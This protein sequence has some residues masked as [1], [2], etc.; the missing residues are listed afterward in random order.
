MIK[1]DAY[2][3]ELSSTFELRD[4]Y[5]DPQ[6]A[7]LLYIQL[8]YQYLE[9]EPRTEPDGKIPSALVLDGAE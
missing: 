4:T 8:T 2:K 9:S 5:R 6:L 1:I 7:T 3:G